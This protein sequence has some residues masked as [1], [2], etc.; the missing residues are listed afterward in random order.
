VSEARTLHITLP[1]PPSVNHTYFTAKNGQRI[2]TT[3]A[4]HWILGAQSRAMERVVLDH[5]E[6][7][8]GEKVIVEMWCYWPDKRR[9]DTHNLDK[10]LLDSLEGVVFDDDKWALPRWMDFS[11]DKE[12][13]RVELAIRRMSY[14]WPPL[15]AVMDAAQRIAPDPD[16]PMWICADCA[17]KYGHHAIDIATWHEDTCGVCGRVTVVTEPRDAGHLKDGWQSHDSYNTTDGKWVTNEA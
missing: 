1:I 3:D 14:M 10:L 5:W 11:V 2:L 15:K 17:E 9:R 4:K 12:N 16:Y 13:P 7:T 6:M 8:T